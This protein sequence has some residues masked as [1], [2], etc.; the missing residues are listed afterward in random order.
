MPPVPVPTYPPPGGWWPSSPSQAPVGPPQAGPPW[1]PQAWPPPAG[2]QPAG[3]SGPFL[4]VPG[5]VP[6]DRGKAVLWIVFAL[7]G[8]VVGQ[9]VGS[10][11][12]LLAAAVQG[13]LHQVSSLSHL[14]QPPAW[15]IAS[16][17]VGLWVG[18]FLAPL[19]AT[20]AQGSGSFVRD[21]GL[22]FR[23]VDLL[24]I[25]IGVG[26]QFVI[27]ALYLPFHV[28]NLTAPAQKLTGGAHGGAFLVIAL[29]TVVGAPFFEELFFRGVL[30]RGLARLFTPASAARVG[31]RAAG[32][33]LAVVVDGLVVALAHF[34][35]AQFA[36][37][38]LFGMALAAVSYR[39]GRLGM[40]MVAHA[41]FNLVA[42]IALYSA[43]GG[44][45]LH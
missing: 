24:G 42:V 32:V 34:E 25:V 40:N 37:L 8:Y 3:P 20:K 45:I 29:L 15:Y 4:D 19:V 38:A 33:V 27:A 31:A 13:Q 18:F 6:V 17:L 7:L 43:R 22:R 14:A 2:P 28:K 44:V 10:V 39:T 5:S 1:P 16:G 35:P 21:F 36:G 23:P 30:F 26:G 41:S 11:A 12:V 9:L